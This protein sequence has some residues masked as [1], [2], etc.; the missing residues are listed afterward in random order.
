MTIS[1][2]L[3]ALCG[4]VVFVYG[5]NAAMAHELV[6]AESLFKSGWS[7]YGL[8]ATVVGA[9]IALFGIYIIFLAYKYDK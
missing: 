3:T 1:R 5:L 4:G 9:A 7:L 8:E 2:L 6:A